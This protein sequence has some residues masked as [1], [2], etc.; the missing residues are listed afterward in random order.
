MFT[1]KSRI[2]SLILAALLTSSAL[3]SCAAETDTITQD[4]TAVETVET[5]KETTELEARQAMP[6]NL[7][8]DLDYEGYEFTILTYSPDSYEV[9]ELSGDV[10]DDSI[11]DRSMDILERFNAVIKT[12]PWPAS[13]SWTRG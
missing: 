13:P 5:A 8:T 10:V 6:D 11:Y 9:E 3:L 1:N 4:T 7:P 2:V 12:A